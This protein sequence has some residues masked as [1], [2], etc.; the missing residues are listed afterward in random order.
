[1]QV[2][3]R[4]F[5]WLVKALLKLIENGCFVVFAIL[6]LFWK[7]LDLL[8]RAI[9]SLLGSLLKITWGLLVFLWNVASPILRPAARLFH[10]I[11]RRLFTMKAILVVNLLSVV[12]ASVFAT[13]Q[14]IAQGQAGS[15]VFFGIVTALVFLVIARLRLQILD[16]IRHADDAYRK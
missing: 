13:A 10:P 5:D 14:A 16:V 7:G 9:L 6:V 3:D 15:A 1:M 11:T 8:V 4:G 2:F 12:C